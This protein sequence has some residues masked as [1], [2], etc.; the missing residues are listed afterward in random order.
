MYVNER[1]LGKIEQFFVSLTRTGLFNNFFSC[2][3]VNTPFLKSD[4]EHVGGVIAKL[5]EQY[6]FLLC[7]VHGGSV[8]VANKLALKEVLEYWPEES[9]QDTLS[10]ISKIRF[11]YESSEQALFKIVIQNDN[12]FFIFDHS[13]YDGMST[14]KVMD[15]FIDNLSSET[16]T[17]SEYVFEREAN[18]EYQLPPPIEELVQYIG[19]ITQ[20][21]TTKAKIW[22]SKEL[23][24]DNEHIFEFLHLSSAE[25]S[26][27]VQMC[28]LNNVTVTPFLQSC[29]IVAQSRILGLGETASAITFGVDT[30][31]YIKD[32]SRDTDIGCNVL[33]HFMTKS[34]EKVVDWLEIQN[35]SDTL[36]KALK[37]GSICYPFG[38]YV[39]GRENVDWD[40]EHISDSLKNGVNTRGNL[41]FTNLGLHKF[42]VKEGKWAPKKSYFIQSTQNLSFMFAVNVVSD[43]DG[44]NFCC[45]MVQNDQFT[46][47][48]FQ[49][50]LIEFKKVLLNPNGS[51]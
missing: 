46:K 12:I 19:P 22:K 17:C 10:K 25:S 40:S 43:E 29:F 31:R 11:Q 5:I 2:L 33:G 6:P 13:I 41:M 30:R 23:C 7:N 37:D 26:Q 18:T 14:V 51:L 44:M 50:V 39:V 48:Q 47:E 3:T 42:K 36:S 49:D 27:I 9:M 1:K 21:P 16:L 4:L 32:R 8:K 24:L 28:K 15:F 35:T 20:Q 45:S 34:N 38:G